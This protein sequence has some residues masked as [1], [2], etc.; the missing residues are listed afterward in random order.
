MIRLEFT[1]QQKESFHY[2]RFHYPHPRVQ[3]KME[4]LWLK[5]KNLSHELIC[6]IANISPNT[7]RAYLKDYEKGGI[8]KLK[9]VNFYKPKSKLIEHFKTIEGYFREHPPRTASEALSKITELTGI[10]RS[11]PQIRVFLKNIGMSLR[12]VG[13]IP[14]KALGEDKKKNKKN[15]KKRN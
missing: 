3:Q 1:E 8:E 10:K 11:L 6:D 2:E 9:E 15:L 13:P 14:G 12:K 4:A 5:S 7:L